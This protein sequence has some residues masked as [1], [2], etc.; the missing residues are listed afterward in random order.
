[1]VC[2]KNNF[3]PKSIVKPY[4]NLEYIKFFYL[5]QNVI[6]LNT[7]N[8]HSDILKKMFINLWIYL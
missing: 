3:I 1:M 5:L 7:S 2:K 8:I 4:F 6:K